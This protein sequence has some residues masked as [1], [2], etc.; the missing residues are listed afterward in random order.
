MIGIDVGYQ[1]LAMCLV[2]PI[3][4]SIIEDQKIKITGYQDMYH[5]FKNE[6]INDQLN[7]LEITKFLK[8]EDFYDKKV[9]LEDVHAFPKQGV[10]STFK[11]AYSK[12][13]LIGIC[14]ALGYQIIMVSPQA[15]KN[16]YNLLTKDKKMSI[17]KA[18]EFLPEESWSFINKNHNNA[19]AFLLCN[20]LRNVGYLKMNY[21]EI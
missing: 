2:H 15:W 8:Q 18:K 17:L 4:E 1:G 6:L 19:E 14:K 3:A 21:K 20:L 5:W 11:F 9:I 13:L 7:V 10:S 12:G 16:Y